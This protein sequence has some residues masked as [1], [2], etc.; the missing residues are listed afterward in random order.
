MGKTLAAK[1]CTAGTVPAKESHG[2]IAKPVRRPAWTQR[3]ELAAGLVAEGGLS[4]AEI[5]DRVGIAP[6]TL[7]NWKR[8]PEFVTRV[9]ELLDAFRAAVRRRGIAVLERRVEALT[10]R[11]MRMQK[12][13][14]DRANDADAAEIP[15]GKTGL[16]VKVTKGTGASSAGKGAG[17]F[18]LDIAL[19]KELR[20]HEKQAAQELGQWVESKTNDPT[21]K[22]Y[23][24][25]GP[26]DL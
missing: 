2:L 5:C 26:D 19:L 18:V 14:E 3:H 23:V 1:R 17:E 4:N 6:T 25:V 12:I 7:A 9:D 21:T 10:D 8:R 15:G 13:I 22:L 20:E 11:W 24:T 16:L